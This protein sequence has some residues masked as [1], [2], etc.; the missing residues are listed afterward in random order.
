MV[1]V[2]FTSTDDTNG[3]YQGKKDALIQ[4]L[5]KH[6][7]IFAWSTTEMYGI[8]IDVAF[9]CL[10]ANLVVLL[11]KQ[12]I[13]SSTMTLARSIHEEEEEEERCQRWKVFLKGLFEPEVI[14]AEESGLTTSACVWGEDGHPANVGKAGDSEENFTIRNGIQENLRKYEGSEGYLKRGDVIEKDDGNLESL[15][16]GPLIEDSDHTE[17]STIKDSEAAQ[18][19]AANPAIPFLSSS[20]YFMWTDIIPCIS[21]I[22]QMMS[23]R[24]KRKALPITQ[25]NLGRGSKRLAPIEEG[26]PRKGFSREDSEKFYNMDHANIVQVGPSNN[27]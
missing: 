13:W 10:N 23:H 4:N 27:Y 7:N 5:Q 2:A 11:V 9:H 22:E 8:P 3:S 12:K 21:P 19:T 18:C 15:Y 20:K 14:F 24:V 26:T 1:P 17:L 25:Q 16:A 6:C